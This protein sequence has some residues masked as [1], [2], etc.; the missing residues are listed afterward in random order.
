LPLLLAAADLVSSLAEGNVKLPNPPPPAPSEEEIAD[1]QRWEAVV[2][3][4]RAQQEQRARRR[5]WQNGLARAQGAPSPAG[6]GASVPIFR[7]KLT[8]GLNEFERRL[9]WVMAEHETQH[10]AFD[11]KWLD[12]HSKKYIP[13]AAGGVSNKQIIIA[14][15]MITGRRESRP[16]D[17]SWRIVS[18][19]LAKETDQ[20][21]LPL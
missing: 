4:L 14:A 17:E 5:R 6:N 9:R 10:G 8:I 12:H 19:W 16:F 11:P 2:A 18:D 3:D 20:A 13:S 21:E 7:Q 15:S 1:K